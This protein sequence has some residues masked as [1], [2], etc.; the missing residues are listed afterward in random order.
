LENL[1]FH[2]EEEKNDPAFSKSL[3]GLADLFVQ[4]AFGAVHRAHA[5]TAGRAETASQRGRVFA[6]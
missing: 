1:R 6:S 2:G 3:A 4:D 5:S